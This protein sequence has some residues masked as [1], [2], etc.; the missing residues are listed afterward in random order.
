V[1]SGLDQLSGSVI[2]HLNSR[3]V[4]QSDY[5]HF[6]LLRLRLRVVQSGLAAGSCSVDQG[7]MVDADIPLD[8]L[9][10]LAGVGDAL[11]RDVF[12]GVASRQLDFAVLNGFN[13]GL[14][15]DQQVYNNEVTL[16]ATRGDCMPYSHHLERIGADQ[17]RKSVV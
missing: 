2:G 11:L 3:S 1:Q 7:N 9:V 15:F 4:I 14:V 6:S 5:F 8:E 16:L 13:R 10:F 17:D 12:G